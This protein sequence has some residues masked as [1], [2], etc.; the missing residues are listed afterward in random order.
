MYNKGKNIALVYLYIFVFL[1]TTYRIFAFGFTKVFCLEFLISLLFII[2]ISCLLSL[3][4]KFLPAKGNF[5]FFCLIIFLFCL[6]FSINLVFYKTYSV[7]LSTSYFTLADQL[8]NYT[9]S[10][11]SSIL[12]NLVFIVILFFPFIFALSQRT[13]IIFER[14]TFSQFTKILIVTVCFG[15]SFY[16]TMYFTRHITTLYDLYYKVNNLSLTHEKAGVILSTHLDIKRFIFGFEEKIITPNKPGEDIVIIDPT[17]DPNYL[18]ID[19][20]KLSSQTTNKEL[21]EVNN[22]YKNEKGTLMNEYTGYYKGKN[23]IFIV[24]ESFNQ[25]A[26]SKKLTP[27]LY[28]LTNESFVFENF[29]TP[30][31]LSTIGGEFQALNGQ[32]ADNSYLISKWRK[33][34]MST[35]YGLGN[36]F[37]NLNYQTYAFHNGEYYF[38]ERDDYLKIFGFNNYIG[39]GNGMEKLMDCIPW[40]RSDLKMIKATTPKYISTST[41]PFMTYFMTNSGHFPY[42]TTGVMFREYREQVQNLPY[43]GPVKA[44]IASQIDLDLALK[45]LI[46]DLTLAQKLDDTVIVLVADHYPYDLSIQEI[47]ELSSYTRDDK[48]EINRSNL[49]I[50]NSKTPITKITKVGGQLDV[51]PTV[52]NLFGIPYDSRLFAG[53][54][55][56]STEPGL[57][58]FSNRSWVSD[59]GKYVSTT[60][61]FT[62][63]NN[64]SV[65]ADYVQRTNNIV[66][67]RINLSKLILKYD[68][69]RLIGGK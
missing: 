3:L 42:D 14:R 52:Y 54:D 28:K 59:L 10:V 23:L 19:F 48:I 4:G 61:I 7:N 60:N 63:I 2:F 44:Y 65:D 36:V 8:A 25:I 50:W 62:P 9:G 15:L 5:I 27:T 41:S 6:V 37:N 31:N 66:A 11:V 35:P 32:F 13:K 45:Q 57:V 17:Y 55:I 68:Y 24:A 20:D 33:A 47:N 39:C 64:A 12:S 69:Y 67:N 16:A 46:D 22:Y 30:L 18:D 49:I 1:E 38:Q 40:P 56:L 51:I 43:S 34:V 26:V 58:F 29:Y 21:I 53:K